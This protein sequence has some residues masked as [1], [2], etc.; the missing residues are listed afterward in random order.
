MDK[1]TLLQ[2]YRKVAAITGFQEDKKKKGWMPKLGPDDFRSIIRQGNY[3]G[4]KAVIKVSPYEDLLAIAR[5]YRRYQSGTKGKPVIRVPLILRSGKVKG[6]QFLIQQSAPDGERMLK[7]YPLS[8]LTKKE[9]VA[10]LYWNTVRYFPL[11]NFDR[12]TISDYFL[13]RL[14]RWFTIGRESGAVESGF[15]SQKEKSRAVELTFSNLGKLKIESFFAHF[16]NT[17]IVKSGGE[18]YIWDSAIV[19]KPEAA[20]IALW[21]WGATL[22]AYKLPLVR[23][24]KEIKV[25]I[26]TFV[27]F[28]PKNR[29]QNL[30]LK[31]RIN[32]LERML[33]SLLVDLP[34]KR[35]PFH[36]LS[37]REVKQ[38]TKVVRAV[39]SSLL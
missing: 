6:A 35:S 36:N 4:R 19:P 30:R 31:I 29:R 13:E 5:D 27:K 33:G 28:A 11:F 24:L 26:E 37:Q 15:I 34:L 3:K 14:D 21:I 10:R 17:D 25:W 12:W 32:L 38:A 20:G 7:N 8:T 16:A 23:W 1:Q 39:L 18:Y 2:F 22:Y 9:E